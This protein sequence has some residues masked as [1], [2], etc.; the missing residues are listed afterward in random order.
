MQGENPEGA[1]WDEGAALAE[2]DR[3]HRAID[4][5]RTRRKHAGAAFDEFVSGFRTPP[6]EQAL[7]ESPL[8][9]RPRPPDRAPG[10]ASV[11]ETPVADSPRTVTLAP[12]AEAARST[13]PAA[14]SSVPSPVHV[15]FPLSSIVSVLV[16]ASTLP[17]ERRKRR[18]RLG[19]VAGGVVVLTT[20]GV[21]LMRSW[22]ATPAG[23]HAAAHPASFPTARVPQSAVPPAAQKSGQVDS[24]APRTEITALRRVWVRVVVDGTSEVERELQAQDRVPLRPG[25]TNVIRAG[26]A[27]AIRLTINGKDQ[28]KLGDDGEVLT[29]TLKIPPSPNR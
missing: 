23:S 3:L 17:A 29:R 25:R 4:E 15:E 21:L 13:E 9:N 2:L 27:G 7:V 26:D 20:A 18:A 22:Q 19:L 12:V 1:P 8:T 5:W 16:K 6:R 24:N 14:P 28:G 10:L 11:L